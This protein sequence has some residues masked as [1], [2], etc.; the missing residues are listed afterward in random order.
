MAWDT[1]TTFQ[2]LPARH[3]F[4]LIA[5]GAS[6]QASPFLENLCWIPSSVCASASVF[7]YR[8][9]SSP[10]RL[11]RT[12]RATPDKSPSQDCQTT[13][14]HQP[15]RGEFG[16]HISLESGVC[17]AFQIYFPCV[18]A[19]AVPQPIPE[20]SSGIGVS[21]FCTSAFDKEDD[22]RSYP[23]LRVV[24]GYDNAVDGAA[25]EV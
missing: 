8:L 25:S 17:G 22:R 12:S 4:R 9:P 14:Q 15:Q 13:H 21:F 24:V 23:V 5:K 3:D 1:S 2:Y 11:R 16:D 18:P 10:F 6:R 19:R 7:A 20:T